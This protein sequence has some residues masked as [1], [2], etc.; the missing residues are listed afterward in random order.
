MRKLGLSCPWLFALLL[1]LVP[2]PAL[3]FRT[4]V[5]GKAL[6]PDIV[7]PCLWTGAMR[8]GGQGDDEWE[9]LRLRDEA[10]YGQRYAYFAIKK[11][12][13]FRVRCRA[14]ET[15]ADSPCID[16]IPIEI[17]KLLH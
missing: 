11:S 2:L 16:R 4:A 1:G 5:P 17:P 3:P 7:T 9:E 6:R 14:R 10:G 8:G 12:D 13:G 15:S